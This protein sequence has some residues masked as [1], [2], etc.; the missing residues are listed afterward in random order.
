MHVAIE[1]GHGELAK[2]LV[3]VGGD[4]TAKSKDGK[5]PLEMTSDRKLLD[6]LT[7]DQ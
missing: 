1:A 6:Y 7:R 5:T 3:E 2:Y 4:L